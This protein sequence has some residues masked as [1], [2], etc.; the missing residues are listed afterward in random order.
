MVDSAICTLFSWEMDVLSGKEN[1]LSE[2]D[3]QNTF[4]Q[5]KPS[6]LS[7][8]L[9]SSGGTESLKSESPDSS[10][11]SP[12]SELTLNALQHEQENLIQ[13][14]IN[15]RTTSMR[16]LTAYSTPAWTSLNTYPHRA[17]TTTLDMNG[18]SA[19]TTPCFLNTNPISSCMFGGNRAPNPWFNRM[20]MP[21]D[22]WAT[23]YSQDPTMRSR[24][25]FSSHQTRELEREFNVCQYITRRR[26][27][28]LAYTLNL[29]E[30]QIKT[31]FQNRRVK[32]RKQKKTNTETSVEETPGNDT[33]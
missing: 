5:T 23:E 27:I 4:D 1:N 15:D 17:F 7:Y 19:T 12:K 10:A 22:P 33:E 11:K 32:E 25:C 9:G 28:E 29:T 18:M 16:N 24:P 20:A 21:P 26:R 6:Y 14:R 31:W 13:Q 2:G 3:A 8:C 30:K